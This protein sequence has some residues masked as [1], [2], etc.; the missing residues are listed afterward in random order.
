[1]GLSIIKKM[2][3]LSLLLLISLNLSG[4]TVLACERNHV[5]HKADRSHECHKN[6]QKTAHHHAKKE[7]DK[8]TDC[9]VCQS[10]LCEEFNEL[11]TLQENRK[12]SNL[13][14]SFETTKITHHTSSLAIDRT[15][16]QT[17]LYYPPPLIHKD[18]NWHAYYSVF[19]N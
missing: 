11:A 16:A 12:S 14:K 17:R 2:K 1:M 6:R 19:L 15:H 5:A 8:K 3:L 7:T 10:G 4:F 9:P 13:K 18:Q